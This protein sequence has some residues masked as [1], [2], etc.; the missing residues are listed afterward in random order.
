MFLPTLREVPT[1]A[2]VISHQLMFRAGM[3]RKLAA[4]IYS[5]LPLGLRVLRKVE[6]I[7]REEMNRA[8]AQEVLLPGVQPAELWQ[9]SGRWEAYGKELLRLKDRHDREFCLG[10]THEEVIT[11]LVRNEIRS[12]KQLPLNLYQIQTKFRDEIRPRF[13]V[14]RGRE[15][16]MKDAYSFDQDEPGVEA[17]YRKMFE[18]YTRI[19]ERCGLRFRSVEAQ[20]GNIGGSFSHEF[21]VL[22]DTGEDLIAVCGRCG[23]AANLEKAEVGAGVAVKSEEPMAPL[24]KAPTPGRRTVEEVCAFL[25]VPA[26]KLTKTLIFETSK[27]PLA[28]LVRGDRE[29]NPFKLEAAAGG[30][31]L[32]MASAEVIAKVTGGPLGFS[33]PVGLKLPIFTD[34]EVAAMRNF[35]TGAN[36]PD[37]HYTGANPGRDFDPGTVADLRQ[38]AEGDPCPRCEGSLGMTRGIE[39]GHVFKLG[40]KYSAAMKATFLD[41]EGKERLLVMGCYGIGT[42]RTVAAAI[43]QNH[44]ES[45]IIWPVPLAPFHVYLLP[46]NVNDE[47]VKAAADGLERDLLAAGLEVVYDD[48]AERPGVKFKDADLLGIPLRIVVGEKTLA[49]GSVEFK[50]RRDKEARLV[51]LAEA[52][53]QSKKELGL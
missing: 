36:A 6:N 33:G 17:A 45:G 12:Y 34:R 4:G 29:L 39:V 49:K 38:A 2:E 28:A 23:Y 8:G 47:K 43:E 41:A 10:P 52:V 11:D 44:D 3:I 18:A 26:S 51:P 7:V 16:G 14:M 19:F 48:R 35:V 53:E 22:A 32:A 50:R 31:G 21:M 25:K 30:S 24:S 40:T 20:S 13:G 9:E 1:E 37:L 15:F 46:I 27:G 5:W 42:G